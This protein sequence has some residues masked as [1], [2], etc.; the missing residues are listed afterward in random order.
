MAFDLSNF[1]TALASGGARPSLFT[2]T[3]TGIAIENFEFSCRVAEIPGLTVTP[4][5]KQYFGR[6]L[7]IPG[8]MV[9]ADLTTTIF[10]DENY[11]VRNQIESWMDRINSHL[12]NVRKFDAEF[13]SEWATGTVTQYSQDGETELM[14]ITFNGLWPQNLDAIELSYDTASD[15]EEFGCTWAYQYFTIEGNTGSFTSQ[16]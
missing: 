9:F 7:K 4:I 6:T 16:G 10:N 2:M 5:E 14:K 13:G 1:K 3:I 15:I 8:D 11:S 12:T